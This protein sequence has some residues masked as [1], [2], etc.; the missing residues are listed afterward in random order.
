MI[1]A[2]AYEEAGDDAVLFHS[3]SSSPREIVN[4]VKA[5]PGRVPIVLV[6][7]AYPS[8]TEAAIAQLEKVRIVIYGNHAIRAATQAMRAVFAQI[9]NDDGTHTVGD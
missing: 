7:N 2:L 8:L 5:W 6:P 4:V 3:K 9:C 1:G